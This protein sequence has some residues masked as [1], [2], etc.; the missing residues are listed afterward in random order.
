MPEARICWRELV[1][2]GPSTQ[3]DHITNPCCQAGSFPIE[4]KGFLLLLS[5]ENGWYGTVSSWGGAVPFGV[6]RCDEM[7]DFAVLLLRE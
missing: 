7:S 3:L 6:C 4:T 2:E 1:D 5:P